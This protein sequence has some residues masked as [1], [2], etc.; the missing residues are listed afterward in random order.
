MTRSILCG[1]I[2]T[3]LSSLSIAQT[4]NE[5]ECVIKAGKVW[6]TASTIQVPYDLKKI[7]TYHR[8]SNRV[9]PFEYEIN[10][11]QM[12]DK[13]VATLARF[14]YTDGQYITFASSQ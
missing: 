2:V 7:G 13:Y 3:F 1:L 9:D 8:S 14:P 4:D 10:L 6:E 5:S 12:N 11:Y